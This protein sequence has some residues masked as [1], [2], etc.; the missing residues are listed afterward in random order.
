MRNNKRLRKEAESVAIHTV[1]R[2]KEVVEALWRL[3][4]GATME[5]S[6]VF[7]ACL[8]IVQKLLCQRSKESMPFEHCNNSN[9]LKLKE[10]ILR[11]NIVL[12]EALDKGGNL[13]V[14]MNRNDSDSI[15]I[16]LNL[17]ADT[18]K[19][20]ESLFQITTETPKDIS[21]TRKDEKIILSEKQREDLEKI[22]RKSGSYDEPSVEK[23]LKE[24]GRIKKQK[25]DAMKLVKKPCLLNRQNRA[26]ELEFRCDKMSKIKEVKK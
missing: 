3:T 22:L 15:S 17:S 7:S 5:Y 14:N 12:E 21:S 6:G 23:K 16:V 13:V 10:E 1:L 11:G 19:F 24:K 9:L 26:D 20:L 18:R 8:L 4:D 25:S 2:N